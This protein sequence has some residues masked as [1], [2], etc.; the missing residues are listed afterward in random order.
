MN[1]A[2]P[3]QGSL[4]CPVHYCTDLFNSLPPVTRTVPLRR[5]DTS[6]LHVRCGGPT[7]LG[8]SRP[9]GLSCNSSVL[10][11]YIYFCT[12]LALLV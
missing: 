2:P 3:P 12:S 5:H 1:I 10:L 7:D 4:S 11:S 9:G 8:V 6:A